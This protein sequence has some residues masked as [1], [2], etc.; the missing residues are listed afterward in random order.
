MNT[1]KGDLIKPNGRQVEVK[2]V[3]SSGP[4]SFGPREQWDELYIIDVRGLF[5]NND[6]KIVKIYKIDQTNTQF[7]KLYVNKTQ[8]FSDQCEQM[9]RPRCQL[10]QLSDFFKDS[11]KLVFD[12]KID[13]LFTDNLNKE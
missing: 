10:K 2:C 5:H 1:K 9:R 4:I 3:N 6:T 13:Y 8:T 11:F 12:D 7:G